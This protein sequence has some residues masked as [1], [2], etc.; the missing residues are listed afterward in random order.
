MSTLYTETNLK[1]DTITNI[2]HSLTRNYREYTEVILMVELPLHILEE[3][4]LQHYD[5]AVRF[6]K[7]GDTFVWIYDIDTEVYRANIN[8]GQ[9]AKEQLLTYAKEFC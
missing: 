2:N 6:Y 4:N 1:V 7:D 5:I 8:F 3:Y 9:E